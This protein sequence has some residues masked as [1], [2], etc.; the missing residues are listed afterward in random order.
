[1]KTIILPIIL[2]FTVNLLQARTVIP[3]ADAWSYKPITQTKQNAEQTKVTIPHT[4]NANYIEGTTA[5]SRE[6]MIYYRELEITPEMRGKRLFLY[7]EGVNSVAHIFI[8]KQ[9]AGTHKGGYTAFS[10]EITDLAM[11]GKN[12]LEV[13]VS[14]AY[15]TDVLPVSGDFNIYGGIHRP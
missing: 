7:F 10:F 11:Q 14:N 6:T 1:M 3:L 13:W 4:W 15:R 2:L 5:Y 9:T 8:N 12:N